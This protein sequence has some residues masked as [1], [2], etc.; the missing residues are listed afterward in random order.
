MKSLEKVHSDR[1]LGQEKKDS[2]LQQEAA[3]KV[4]RIPGDDAE[5][6]R[7]QSGYGLNEQELKEYFYPEVE[8]LKKEIVLMQELGEDSHI[9]RI[10]ILR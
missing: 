4:V 3:I 9:V 8:K 7:V 6:K 5:L 10:W 1:F 2:E